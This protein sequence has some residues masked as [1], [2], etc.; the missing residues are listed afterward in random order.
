MPFWPLSYF[1]PIISRKF[2]SSIEDYTWFSAK[3]ALEY[4]RNTNSFLG[5][6]RFTGLV[7]AARMKL[8]SLSLMLLGN[9]ISIAW[10]SVNLLNRE[11]RHETLVIE[12]VQ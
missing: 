11:K 4:G 5:C 6:D 3:D 1:W 7:L 10:L 12:C 8:S 2:A 9:F